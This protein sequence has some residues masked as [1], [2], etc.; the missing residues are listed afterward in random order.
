[1]SKRSAHFVAVLTAL[2][3]DPRTPENGRRGAR[4]A[5]QTQGAQ[6]APIGGVLGAEPGVS[7][8]ALPGP[9]GDA[10]LVIQGGQWHLVINGRKIGT[11]AGEA[12]LINKSDGFDRVGDTF[13]RSQ[14]EHWQFT[15][16][17][18]VDYSAPVPHI[19]CALHRD[20]RLRL[21]VQLAH[22]VWV[23]DAVVDDITHGTNFMREYVGVV[24]WVRS[25]SPLARQ[26]D[27]NTTLALGAGE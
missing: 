26:I 16:R 3:D 11:W 15:G 22:A 7:A 17:A 27:A 14:N 25:F 4:I 6:A 10:V 13:V 24:L 1:M 8:Q 18:F 23:A 19:F 21:I 2:A 9:E 12:E 5:L 20:M